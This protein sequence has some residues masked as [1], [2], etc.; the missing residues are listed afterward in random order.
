M[1]WHP[2][3]PGGPHPEHRWHEKLQQVEALERAMREARRTPR[4]E[5]PQERRQILRLA[6]DLPTVWQAPPPSR[7]QGAVATPHQADRPDTSRGPTAS[8]PCAGAM[9]FGG[10]HR[11]RGP[12]P[13]EKARLRT[14][15]AVVDAIT[16]PAAGRS[17]EAIAAALNTHGLRSGRGPFTADAVA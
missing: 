7:P 14:P 4:L 5:V 10:D 16:A 6:A 17:D 8:D 1:R 9:A 13:R 15:R 3:P 11:T 12:S 2:K